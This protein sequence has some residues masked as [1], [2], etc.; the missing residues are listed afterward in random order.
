M[1]DTV[2]QVNVPDKK[3]QSPARKL[4]KWP[5]VLIL[6]IVLA[7]VAGVSFY[8]VH[9]HAEH[10]GVSTN[11]KCPDDL[12]SQASGLLNGDPAA[13]QPV[14]AKIRANNGYDQDANCLNVVTTYYVRTGDADN[15]QKSYDRL[16]KVYDPGKGFSPK[17][18]GNAYTM[19]SLQKGVNFVKTSS[20][21]LQQNTKLFNSVGGTKR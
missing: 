2:P 14:V 8:A 5:L 16:V 20:V 4:F 1:T 9:K 7:A 17:L 15:A 10:N 19:D 11:T 12:L 3:T 21:E 6:L 18:G 13:L